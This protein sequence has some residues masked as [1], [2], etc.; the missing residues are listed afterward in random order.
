MDIFLD[1]SQKKANDAV[2]SEKKIY[3]IYCRREGLVFLT[4]TLVTTG[5]VAETV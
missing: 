3:L 5:Q 2:K 4:G 1:V